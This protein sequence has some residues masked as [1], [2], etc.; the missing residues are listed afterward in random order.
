MW[1][2]EIASGMVKRMARMVC[3]KHSHSADRE[4]RSMEQQMVGPVCGLFSVWLVG[5]WMALQ[6]S[7]YPQ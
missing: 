2:W 6:L 7:Q 3:W 5:K 4:G 1:D